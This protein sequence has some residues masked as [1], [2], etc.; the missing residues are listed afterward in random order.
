MVEGDLEEGAIMAG[1][2][3]VL[4]KQIRSVQEIM[5]AIVVEYARAVERL[6]VFPIK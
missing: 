2:S 3:A 1:Q 6:K 4:V 5:D